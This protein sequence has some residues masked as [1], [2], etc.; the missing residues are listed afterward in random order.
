MKRIILCGYNW[1]GCKALDLLLEGKYEVF[2]YTHESP[3]HINNMVDFCKLKNINYSTEKITLKNLPFKP[4]YIISIYYRFLIQE[5]II[6]YVN[7]SIFNLHPSLLP[8]YRGCSSITWAIINGEKYSGFT[9]HYINKDIDSGNIILQL[10]EKIYD[11]DTQE[12]L[13]NRI[14]FKGLDYFNKVLGLVI[15]GYEGIPQF[16]EISSFKRGCPYGGKINPN[17]DLSKKQRF[18]RAMTNPPYKP[19]KYKDK[20]IYTINDLD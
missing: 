9:Y 19:A 7:G 16:G 12:T 3:W 10:K 6:R 17:W 5:D 1:S 4:D 2:V 18:I 20:T 15:D 8:K 11:F 13:Y 14:M